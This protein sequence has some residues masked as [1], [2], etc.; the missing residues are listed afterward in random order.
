VN[1]QRF[2]S[3]VS[4]ASRTAVTVVGWKAL[5]LVQQML[6]A[7][8]VGWIGWFGSPTVVTANDDSPQAYRVSELWTGD[9]HRVSDAVMVVRAGKIEAVGVFSEVVLPADCV[10]HDHRG[11]TMIP[12][13]ILAETTLSEGGADDEYAISPEVRAIDGFDFFAPQH[14]RLAAGV[15]T[16]QLAPGSA[17]LM[18]GQGSVIKL[19]GENLE[20][21]VLQPAESVRILLTPQALSPPTIYE[22]PV[23]AVS[24]A[25]PLL[26]TRPQLA[27]TLSGA[28]TGLQALFSAAQELTPDATVAL[29]EESMATI[30]AALRQGQTF[31]I[32]AQT[33]AELRAA[34]ELANQFELK[35][36]LVSPQNDESLAGVDWKSE[37]WRGVV[38]SPGVR[39]GQFAG[40]WGLAENEDQPVPTTAWELAAA[41]VAAGAETK[42]ALKLESD[43]DIPHL[44]YLAAL[45]Q[46][47]GLSAEQIMSMLTGNP[48]RL[49][50]VAD[51]VGRLSVGLDA[52]FVLLTGQPLSSHT[53]VE[54]TFVDGKEVYRFD[55]GPE[56]R[57]IVGAQVY[58]DGEM[59]PNA[60]VAIA[61]GKITG[62]GTQVSAP[63]AAI[64]EHFPG[65]VIVPGFVDLGTSVGW[66]GPVAERLPLQTKMG[67]YLAADDEQV[68]A[69]RRGGITT[70]LLSSTSLPSPVVAFKLSD[71]PRV[72]Q[73]PVAIRFEVGA[74][75]TQVEVSLRRTLQAGKAYHDSWVKY[76]AEFAAYQGKLKEYE[77]ELAKLEAE[78]K[79]KEADSAGTAATPG[80]ASPAANSSGSAPGTPAP[81]TPAP[82]TPAP[83]TPAPGTPAPGTPAPGTPAPGTPA[84]GTPAPGTQA[85]G[86]PA[87][88]G[89][90]A[91]TTA[92]PASGAAQETT[93]TS[94][95]APPTKP[96]EPTK[97]KLQEALEPYRLLFRQQIPAMVDVADGLGAK[98]ALRLFQDEFKLR[99]IIAG[100]AGLESIMGEVAGSEA[101]FVTGP[102]MLG[103]VAGQTVNYPQLL[104]QRRATFGFQSKSGAAS[105]G[106]PY[107]IGFA[108]HQGLADS[109][110]LTA[111]TSSP[112]DMFGLTSIGKLQAGQDADL[113]VLSGPPFDPGSR[114]LAVM[115]DGQWVYQREVKP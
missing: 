64:V 49:L 37:R 48:A 53:Q 23:G 43:Q 76:D 89:A 61:D 110:A 47:G 106:L 46:Q 91:S 42:M 66:G 114:I 73:D 14:E 70:G 62:V 87:P 108:V 56:T 100:G 112:A 93:A 40:N 104:A 82:G 19:A 109:D 67:D 27:G 101:K 20:Q 13:M 51:R 92:S 96:T 65:A 29:D 103:Q 38:L 30:A 24:E 32:T 22:P 83:G 79:A 44:R 81:G 17:R 10:L 74:N 26:P 55:R 9:G 2:K 25:R 88:A 99:T 95:P 84:P 11:L 115:I 3:L 102:V 111:L 15:T 86:T 97:P 41:L 90:P 69:A 52:D 72:L 68:A 5:T 36:L 75:L 60:R 31:R 8:L 94:E 98:L 28:V 45:L 63:G 16:V 39:P 113:V 78:K 7:G 80:A 18:P 57:V 1:T 107:V 4:R 50:N 34:I 12:G 58:A 6:V 21:R 33:A 105:A 71:R 35:T 59:I 85:Q 54:A 77:A